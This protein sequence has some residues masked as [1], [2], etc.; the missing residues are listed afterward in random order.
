MVE[1]AQNAPTI[2]QEEFRLNARKVS[3]TDR[4]MVDCL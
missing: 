3:G 4:L 1:V 2:E